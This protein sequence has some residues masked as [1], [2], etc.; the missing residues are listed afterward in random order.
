MTF[1][2][3]AVTDD[4]GTWLTLRDVALDIDPA[5]LY[6]RKLRIR[7]A[8]AGEWDQARPPSGQ[9]PPLA[10]LLRMLRLP[11]GMS[12]DRLEIDRLLLAPPVLGARVAAT[13]V[14]D[15]GF[16]GPVRNATLDIH[17]IDGAPGNIALQ[18]TL[19]GEEP[20][21][22]LRLHANDPTG[23]IDDRVFGRTDHLPLTLSLDG[24]GPLADWH[25]RLAASASRDAWLNA[26]L[27][28]AVSNETALDLSAQGAVAALLPP[29]VAS[30]VG[31][32]G[33]CRCMPPSASGSLSTACRLTP[34]PAR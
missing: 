29:G 32:C 9:P 8:K 33:D 5:G 12:V 3:I 20:I 34:P 7:L 27:A 2:R 26:D 18:L 24:N 4:E 1:R 28:L 25:G 10:D 21:L 31:P 13:L 15:L 16:R 11:F 17:R 19:T 14:G 6:A 23:L 30:V 22:R